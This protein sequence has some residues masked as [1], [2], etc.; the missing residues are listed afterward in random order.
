VTE[1][2]VLGLIA[3]GGEL[4]FLCAKEARGRGVER[5]VAIAFPGQ[6]A[7]EL[8][9]EVDEFH[10][11][12]VGQ[13]GKLIKTLRGADVEHAVMV[14]KLDPKLVISRLKLDLRMLSLAARVRDRRADTVLKAI[15][16]EIE[17]D[18]IHLL[19]STT[20]LSSCLAE[21]G[22]MTRRK[23]SDETREDILFGAKIAREIAGLDIG[24]TVVVK[25]KAVVAV[26]AME[27]TD[28]TIRRA[29][30]LCPDGMIVVKVS[31][32]A[33]DMRFDVPVVGGKTIELLVNGKTAALALEAGRTIM[34]DRERFLEEADKARIAVVGI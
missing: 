3:G 16:G 27:G 26:E 34:L 25:R 8:R 6:T 4:P 14:G 11:V 9:T 21:K 29:S 23:P 19:D 28:E 20:Y 2:K 12:H 7:E 22:V 24:Q 31:R 13:L 33:Q 17:K 15:A 18:G 32:P 1:I 10:L 30:S 5:I